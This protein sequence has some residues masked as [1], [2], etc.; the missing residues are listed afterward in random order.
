MSI[1]YLL[2]K[3]RAWVQKTLEKDKDFFLKQAKSQ[4]PNYLWIGCCDSRKPEN[5]ITKLKPGQIFVHRNIG[6]QVKLD[7]CNCLSA[8]D[9]SIK[10]LNI[11][12]IIICGHSNCGAMY[13]AIDKVNIE[14][15]C[16]WIDPISK[17]Y[18]DNID[19]LYFDKTKNKYDNLSILNI[20][21][22][23]LNIKKYLKDKNFLDL[24][25]NIYGLYYNL[26]T[27]LLEKI[28]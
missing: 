3:N 28:I 27:G 4:N 11:K 23:V 1:D 16:N 10:Q 12:D 22:Q 17:F 18:L 9:F 20:K 2:N 15:V 6:N 13:A 26:E 8:V 19:K 24:G 7:D 14:S 25:L 21:Q 5:T